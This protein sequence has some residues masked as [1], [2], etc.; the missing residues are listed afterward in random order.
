MRPGAF[1]LL[2]ESYSIGADD[3]GMAGGRAR[4]SCRISLPGEFPL[5]PRRSQRREDKMAALTSD[6]WQ[7][8]QFPKL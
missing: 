6:G 5:H 1:T 3:A 7:D 8:I 4:R 2:A